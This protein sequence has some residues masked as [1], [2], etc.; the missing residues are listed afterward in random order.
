MSLFFSG[1]IYRH[2]KFISTLILLSFGRVSMGLG[3]CNMIHPPQKKKHPKERGREL[4]TGYKY[5][6]DLFGCLILDVEIHRH[7][8]DQIMISPIYREESGIGG[9]AQYEV[10]IMLHLMHLLIMQVLLMSNYY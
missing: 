8:Q 2:N 5:C 9:R 4:V 7:N 6:N 10:S 3:S 1:P